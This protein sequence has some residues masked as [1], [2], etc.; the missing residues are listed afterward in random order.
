MQILVINFHIMTKNK[1]VK[2]YQDG[3]DDHTAC[4]RI[5]ARKKKNCKNEWKMECQVTIYI[6]KS[7]LISIIKRQLD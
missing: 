3:D 7:E 1:K 5:S 2:T 4:P 6:K